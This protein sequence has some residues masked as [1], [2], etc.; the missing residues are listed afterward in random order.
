MLSCL[1][2]PTTP[3]TL[4]STGPK[5]NSA[6]VELSVSKTG[7]YGGEEEV[8][9]FLIFWF[10]VYVLELVGKKATHYFCVPFLEV[11]YIY[12]QSMQF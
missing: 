2:F 4:F 9:I 1:V 6:P 8:A 7:T 5:K 12:K 10:F 11:N 3:G